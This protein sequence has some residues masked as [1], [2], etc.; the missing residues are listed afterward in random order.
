M[1]TTQ[2]MVITLVTTVQGLLWTSLGVISGL[3]IGFLLRNAI[4]DDWVGNNTL[5]AL[6]PGEW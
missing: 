2:T 5:C 4:G 3:D 1:V 6:S